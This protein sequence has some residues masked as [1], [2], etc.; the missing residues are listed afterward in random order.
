MEWGFE[1]R[2]RREGAMEQTGSRRESSSQDKAGS[3]AKMTP[4]ATS[5]A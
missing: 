3:R 5:I 1:V 4:S 2:M